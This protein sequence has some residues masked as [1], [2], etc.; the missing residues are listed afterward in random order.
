[1]EIMHL[2][3]QGDVY[4]GQGV[5]LLLMNLLLESQRGSCVIVR[6]HKEKANLNAFAL[7]CR[8]EHTHSDS[9]DFA[10]PC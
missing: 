4:W 9:K 7:F 10:A 8:Q 3:L 1:M 6:R 2:A 5:S